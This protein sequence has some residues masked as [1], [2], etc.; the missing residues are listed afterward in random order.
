ME[1]TNIR[2]YIAYV[3][4]CIIWGTTPLA[5]KIG[6]TDLPPLLFAGLRWIPAGIIFTII[7]KLKK[8][9]FP[10]LEEVKHIAVAGLCLLGVGNGMLVICEQWVPS[11]IASL[12]ITTMPFW[13]ILM[14]AMAP[15]G[16]RINLSSV[17]GLVL[18]VLGILLILKDDLSF[19]NGNQ[20][21]L[22][23]IIGLTFGM[24]FWS[25]GSIYSK[26][27]KIKTH[28][29]MSAA[30][31]MLIAGSAQTILGIILGE[32]NEFVFTSDSFYAYLYLVLVAS[33]I[34]YGSYIYAINHLPVSFVTTYTYVNPIIALLLGWAVL[35]ETLNIFIGISAL[36]IL[37]GV[38][39]V[40]KGSLNQPKKAN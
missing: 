20:W 38:F 2:A 14:E 1:K 22:I 27:K 36:I 16:I 28:P 3:V 6:V 15:K 30:I 17:S 13:V 21:F 9:E 19:D 33:I 34:G 26:Y 11:G 31:Q 39:L 10:P 32:H 35:N 23:G 29:L 37:L 18:G 8:Y 40:R 25:F 4:I 7:L 12:M 24:M 5:I